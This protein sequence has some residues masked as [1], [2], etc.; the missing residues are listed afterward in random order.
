MAN[1]QNRRQRRE[2]TS[3]QKGR[4]VGS[5]R[6]R[7]QLVVSS[8]NCER[9]EKCESGR[10]EERFNVLGVADRHRGESGHC[11]EHRAA[12]GERERDSG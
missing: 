11:D 3:S 5:V 4:D 12:V 7:S 10:V 1:Q 8:D 2:I 6:K 9:E